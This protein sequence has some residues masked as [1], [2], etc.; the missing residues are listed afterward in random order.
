MTRRQWLVLAG[1]AALGYSRETRAQPAGDDMPARIATII[2]EYEEQGFHRTGTNV[3]RLSGEWLAAEVTRAGLK[4]GLE[5]FTLTRV[6]PITCVLSARGRRI[7]GLP[8]FDGGFTDVR[9]IRGRLG[10][11]GADADIGLAE[12]APNAAGAGALGEARRANRHKAIVC[13]TRGAW[14]GLC[15]SNADSFLK[16]FGPPV[17]QVSSA[18]ANHLNEIAKTGGDVQLIANVVRNEATAM[19]VTA[20]IEG[21]NGN[22]PPLVIMTPRSGWYWCASERGGGIACWI[23]TIRALAKIRP[24]R[25]VL[26]VASSGH[27][28]GHLGINAFVERRPGIVKASVA[29]MHFGANIGAAI[30]ASNALQASDDDFDALLSRELAAEKLTVDRRVPRGTVPNGEAEVVHRG[31]GRYASIIGRNALFH[32]PDDRGATAVNP[33]AIARFSR[34]FIAVAR[35][36]VSNL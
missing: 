16:P 30:D 1:A 20:S 9:G 7:E 26:F 27:E 14:P 34:A 11:L 13:L 12:V 35:S 5:P 36:F 21:V 33:D 28:L 17:L 6:D 29:W 22:M 18:E 15:P 3:D 24:S 19:N 10:P 2:R 32:N 8:L 25:P 23:E 4:P 31:G